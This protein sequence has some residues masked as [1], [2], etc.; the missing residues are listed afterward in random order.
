MTKLTFLGATET[1]TGSK[2]LLQVDGS[3]LVV[4][5]GLF[6]GGRELRERNADAPGHLA[7]AY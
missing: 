6:Q 2:S 7:P 4:D 1:V 3:K 5:S